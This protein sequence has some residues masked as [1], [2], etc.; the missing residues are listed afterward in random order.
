M[1]KQVRNTVH[2]SPTPKGALV[3]AGRSA[4]GGTQLGAW[5]VSR[6]HTHLVRVGRSQATLETPPALQPQGHV[7]RGAGPQRTQCPEAQGG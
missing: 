1:G 2:S 6:R 5:A 3:T 7:E 4:V